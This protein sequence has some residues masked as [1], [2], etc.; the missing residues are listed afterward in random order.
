MTKKFTV[1]DAYN[2]IRHYKDREDGIEALALATV[3][4]RG[5]PYDRARRS[6]E[7]NYGYLR[8]H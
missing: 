5:W 7:A 8:A 6:A 2:I 4:Y 3:Y 1:G